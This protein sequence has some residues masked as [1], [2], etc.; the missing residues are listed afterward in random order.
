MRIPIR[1]NIFL[2]PCVI[3]LKLSS[4]FES[5]FKFW[6]NGRFWR[7]Y[8]AGLWPYFGHWKI[9]AIFG[10]LSQLIRIKKLCTAL[11]WSW[12]HFWFKKNIS[13]GR[14]LTKSLKIFITASI[15][16]SEIMS[17]SLCPSVRTFVW[18][19]SN[20]QGLKNIKN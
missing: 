18:S 16:Y 20:F 3:Y 17:L 2:Y 11:E 7:Q 19:F 10:F 13:I 12:C 14:R 9:I 6:S 1:F 8:L 4:K 5:S 15:N